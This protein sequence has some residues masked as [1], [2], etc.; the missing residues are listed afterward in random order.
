MF[1]VC[2]HGSVSLKSR[3]LRPYSVVWAVGSEEPI[4]RATRLEPTP[5]LSDVV[6]QPGPEER[7]HQCGL[8]GPRPA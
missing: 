5:L 8:L 4:L 3:T 1:G 7:P 6:Q 2:L